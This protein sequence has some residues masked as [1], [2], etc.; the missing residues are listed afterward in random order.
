MLYQLLTGA[1]PF[2]RRGD[3]A[4][5]YAHI[6]E[7]PPLVSDAAPGRCPPRSTRSSSEAM[8]KEPD[9]RYESAGE[10]ARAAGRDPPSSAAHHVPHAARAGRARGWDTAPV[11]LAALASFGGHA[12]RLGLRLGGRPG[13]HGNRPP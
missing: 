9:D 6:T 5:M 12:V 11:G 4:K 10:L 2:D 13:R 3:M 1:V 7:P 8:A